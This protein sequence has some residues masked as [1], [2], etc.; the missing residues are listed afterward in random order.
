MRASKPLP[1][2]SERQKFGWVS[3]STRAF[4][5]EARRLPRFSPFD[6]IHGYIYARWPYLYIGVGTGEHPLSGVIRLVASLFSKL[7]PSDPNLEDEPS[8]FADTYHGK[9]VTLE[10]A[11]Q[12][13]TVNEDIQLLDL[14][15]VIPYTRARD[16]I[17]KNPKHIVA[18]ECPCRTARPN[19]CLPLDV[20]LVVGEPFASFVVEHHP[21][22]A[23]WVIPEEAVEIL[24]G[25]HSRGHVHHAFF[26]D[27]MFGRFYA[28]CSCCSCCCGARQAMR[29]GTPMLASS[30]YM[31]HVALDLCIECDSC[32]EV[33]PF[34]ALMLE[35][36]VVEVNQEVC[37]G[38]GVCV[39]VCGEGALS[40]IRNYRA[41]EPLE[42]HNLMARAVDVV[43]SSGSN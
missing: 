33:C 32:A 4:L 19:P 40:L 42:I 12:L 5:K 24:E 1:S 8:T 41:G 43:C 30:G 28:I 36:G 10:A 14:E 35:G 26:K 11:R 23:H 31:S 20:C 37:M 22:R 29:N 3:P 27:A 17:L 39:S 9:V 16:I 6:F 34:G 15:Q 25:E 38:C 7:V 21:H 2:R 18:L 13:V